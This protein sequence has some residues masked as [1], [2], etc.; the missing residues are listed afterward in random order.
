VTILP[1]TRKQA[2][3]KDVRNS[4]LNMEVGYMIQKFWKFKN[5]LDWNI[6]QYSEKAYLICLK[7][8]DT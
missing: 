6:L 1:F 2:Q 3:T 8:F 7:T 4:S 5:S